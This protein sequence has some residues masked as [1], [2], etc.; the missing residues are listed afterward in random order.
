MIE[1]DVHL[2]TLQVVRLPRSVCK[3]TPS[4][5]RKWTH[6]VDHAVEV[7]LHSQRNLGGQ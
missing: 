7:L 1:H 3:I 2:V 6:Y 4:K 5:W